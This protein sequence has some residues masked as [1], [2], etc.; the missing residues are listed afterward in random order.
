[1]RER[2]PAPCPIVRFAPALSPLSHFTTDLL[3]F[4][5]LGCALVAQI[6][7]IRSIAATPAEVTGPGGIVVHRSREMMWTVLTAAVL[8]VT[9]ALAW[10]A[11]H[12]GTEHGASVSGIQAIRD[13]QR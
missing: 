3:Y 12:D 11:R 9:F 6:L 4:A 2:V 7:V 8:A 1:M 13:G 10:T 5:A